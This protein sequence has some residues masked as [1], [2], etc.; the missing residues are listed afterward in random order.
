MNGNS[1]LP[2]TVLLSLYFEGAVWTDITENVASTYLK[3]T[4]AII[5]DSFERC[6]KLNNGVTNTPKRIV[7]P[8]PT[9][10]GK[11]LATCYYASQLEEEVGMLIVTPFISEADEIVKTINYYSEENNAIAFHNQ[12]DY[13]TRI[14]ELKEHQVLVITHNQFVGATDRNQNEVGVDRSKI[15]KLYQYLNGKRSVVVID[16]GIETIQETSL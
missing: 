4:W 2:K 3:Q 13:R 15:N 11:T 16:E 7:I 10:T 5:F 14:E 9:G 1:K 8:A 6:K 12:S